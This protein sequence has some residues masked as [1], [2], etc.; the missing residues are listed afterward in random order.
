VVPIFASGWAGLTSTSRYYVSVINASTFY[1]CSTLANAIAGTQID[2]TTAG[3]S[4][5][6]LV[7][8]PLIA[9]AGVAVYRDK[10][11]PDGGARVF[12]CLIT[13]IAGSLGSI[14]VGTLNSAGR[15]DPK[16]PSNSIAAFTA[17]AGVDLDKLYFLGT[18]TTDGVDVLAIR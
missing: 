13:P 9:S 18:D 11:A 12:S 16:S 17:N 10:L 5:T 2:F 6:W 14:T 3:G 4:S 8:T 1:V 15:G 7:A